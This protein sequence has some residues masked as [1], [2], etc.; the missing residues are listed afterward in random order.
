MPLS[1]SADALHIK[2]YQ[3]L[4]SREIRIQGSMV[5]SRPVH[6]IMLD[7][8]AR[9]R[10]WPWIELLPLSPQGVEEAVNRRE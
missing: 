1:V 6:R 2:G 10:S 5:A 7:F 9:T 8:S 4:L 3:Q